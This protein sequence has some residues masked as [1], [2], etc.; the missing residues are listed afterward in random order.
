MKSS[1]KYTSTR[2]A[3]AE[4]LVPAD[5]VVNDKSP[6]SPSEALPDRIVTRPLVPVEPALAVSMVRTPLDVLAPTPE[7]RANEPPKPARELPARNMTLPP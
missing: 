4:P 6:E 2:I 3:P 5:P 1:I 7:E